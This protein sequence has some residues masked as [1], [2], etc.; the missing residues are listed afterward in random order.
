MTLETG[1]VDGGS[2]DDEL[3]ASGARIDGGPGA[4]LIEGARAAAVT[5]ASRTAGVS[6]TL[7]GLANDGEPGEGDNLTGSF[8]TLTGG[9]GDDVLSGG[10]AAESATGPG[11]GIT[12]TGNG[13]ADLLVG[14]A[15]IDGLL[16]GDGDDRLRGGP[17]NDSFTGGAGADGFAGGAGTDVVSYGASPAG[18]RVTIGAGADDGVPGEADDVGA[19][20]ENVD[21]TLHDDVLQGSAAPNVLTG[22]GGGDV[23]LGEGGADTLLGAPGADRIVGGPGP[24]RVWAGGGDRLELAD[25]E[26]DEAVCYPQ[27]LTLEADPFDV[28][29]RCRSRIE[30]KSRRVI[31]TGRDGRLHLAIRCVS[32]SGHPCHG[33]V[34][35][36]DRSDRT[37]LGSAPYHLAGGQRTTVRV[38]LNAAG[39][40]ARATR[41]R[42]PIMALAYPHGEP[43]A[44]AISRYDFT[45]SSWATKPLRRGR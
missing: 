41:F 24:D 2:G 37:R 30:F 23:L 39:R 35:V 12:L 34:R 15:G 11:P 45:R 8:S 20:V 4:D 43:A 7:D 17:G 40:R 14:T 5:Y 6:A 32:T 27:V 36:I 44:A 9:A 29:S 26:V 18:V 25:G 19:D 28:V 13:G 42:V 1:S 21:G 3:R 10:G 22:F 38:K 31:R 33:A 16:G